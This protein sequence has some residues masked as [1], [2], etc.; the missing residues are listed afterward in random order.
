LWEYSLAVWDF[1][2][3]ILHGHTLEEAAALEID[4]ATKEITE[5]Y[6]RYQKDPF[7]IP[8]HLSSLFTT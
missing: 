7:I 6:A 3:G 8:C 4:T 5:A 1:R 2:N